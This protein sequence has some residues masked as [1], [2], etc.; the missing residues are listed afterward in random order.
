MPH[1]LTVGLPRAAAP[2]GLGLAAPIALNS[3][4]TGSELGAW[5]G[6]EMENRAG[7]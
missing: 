3:M 4:N 1:T 7:W 2:Y 5:E 6:C